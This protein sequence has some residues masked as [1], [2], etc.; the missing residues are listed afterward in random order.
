MIDLVFL[1]LLLCWIHYCFTK[2]IMYLIP[3]L[4]DDVEFELV[5]FSWVSI[6]TPRFILF[7][8]P[9]CGASMG[10][11]CPAARLLQAVIFLHLLNQTGLGCLILEWEVSES[12]EC[13]GKEHLLIQIHRRS[14]WSQSG[15]WW[16]CAA[17][18]SGTAGPVQGA[19]P[20]TECEFCIWLTGKLR[21]YQWRV[22]GE[23]SV[24]RV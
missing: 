4:L 17:G 13:F 24:G 11:M 10:I 14:V 20:Q 1:K 9:V 7:G 18:V 21:R 16:L 23:F 3:N 6:S 5:S 8:R 2:Y 19:F 15:G 12:L 22:Q